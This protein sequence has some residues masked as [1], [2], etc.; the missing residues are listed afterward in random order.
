MKFEVFTNGSFP[1]PEWTRDPLIRMRFIM[2][3]K[4]PGS[5]EQH[6]AI[7]ERH[8]NALF[9]DENDVIKFVINDENDFEVAIHV[10]RQ[11]E[12]DGCEASFWVGKV[13]GAEAITD[14]WLVGRMKEAKLNW[15]L[16]VQVHKFIWPANKQG[17]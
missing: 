13:W 8:K 17:V 9:L 10:A 11:L 5:W 7:D 6:T 1:F 12:G 4:L 16:N 3:W 14:E 15:K 2:D